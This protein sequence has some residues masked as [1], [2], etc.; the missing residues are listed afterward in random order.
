MEKERRQQAFAKALA[1]EELAAV[2]VTLREGVSADEVPVARRALKA[3]VERVVVRG[4]ELRIDYRGE[5]L[6]A[7]GEVPPRGFVF[8]ASITC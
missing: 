6:L 3:F 2:L 7:L 8:C 4:D 1:P 5:V